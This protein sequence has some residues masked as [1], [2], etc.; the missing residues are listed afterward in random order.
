MKLSNIYQPYLD[1]IASQFEHMKQLTYNWSK[2]NSGSYNVAGLAQMR[3]VLKD[4]F[5][6][7]GVEIEEIALPPAQN[8][9]NK[10]ELVEIPLG[11]ALRMRKRP[12]AKIQVFLGGHY[13]TVFEAN[14]HFQTPVLLNDN[15]INGPGV[16]DLKGGLVVM[17]KALEALERSPFAENI[18]YEIL[19]NPDEEIG[20]VGSDY[21]LK[22]AASRNHIGL[23]Y[24]PSFSD[25]T[26]VSSRK[27]SGNFSLIVRGKAAHAGREHHLGRN[28]VVHASKIA[29]CLSELSANG[30]TVNVAKIE[31]GAALN[32]VPDIAI[33]QFNVRVENS[34][35]QSNM[36]EKLQQIIA[37]FSDVDYRLELHGSF[38]RPAKI[39]DERH[40]RLWNALNEVGAMLGIE[41]KSKPS[42]GCCDGNNL[43]AYGLPNIDTLGVIGGNI[44]SE[45]E[46]VLLDSLV[47]RAQL[48]ALLL[49]RIAS[50]EVKL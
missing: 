41:I 13:D 40:Q 36:L 27:G 7:L 50:G 2:I 17:L 12:D 3:E 47:E 32:V 31:G 42:G 44:H 26:L 28:A 49:L 35:Q 24:E 43:S 22:E 38:T 14:H 29:V 45:G 25:G 20:S 46:Y 6:W 23:I 37:D 48:S 15:V 8:V 39:I 30:L 19:L 16:A 10:G 9:N 34:A 33:I 1:F 5:Y 18:G 21:L 11:L 4:N